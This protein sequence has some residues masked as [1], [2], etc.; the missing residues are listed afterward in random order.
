MTRSPL[1]RSRFSVNFGTLFTEV[2][3]PERLAA[4]KACGFEVVEFQFPYDHT[5][6]ELNAA[7]DATGMRLNNLN[8]P[9]GD[10]S[11]DEWGHA[12]IPGREEDFRRYFAQ[13]VDYATALGAPLIHVMS[14]AV[15]PGQHEAGL[16]TYIANIRA[17]ARSVADKGITLLLE[18][19]N[20]YDRPGNLV[21]RSDDIVA[22]I[23][24][25]GE[26]NVKLM[27]DFYHIQ[28]MEGDLLRRFE[29]HMPHIGHVQIANAPL[30]LAPDKGEI[31]YPAIFEAIAASPYRGP[32][33][34]EYKPTG[35][36]EDDFGW[37]EAFGIV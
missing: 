27:F 34:L 25:I 9:R 35:R 23:D 7:L 32:V 29:R 21:S 31:N 19:L 11:R 3:L 22:L 18:P 6:E 20:R 24:E 33:G 26:P 15:A 4:A 12:G 16:T 10:T 14:G 2:P 30:R 1:P 37:M 28:V 36:T 17:A 5:I 13:A 8:T